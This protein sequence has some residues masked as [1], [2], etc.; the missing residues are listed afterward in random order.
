MARS[1]IAYDKDLP[2]VA[3]RL[4]W[5][6]PT[7]HLVKDDDAPTGWREDK[8]GRRPSKLLL[9]PKIRAEVDA[10]RENGYPGASEVTQR[11]FAYWFEEDHDVPGFPAPFRY[12]FCQREAIETL[13]WLVEV[14]RQRDAKALVETYGTVYQSDLVSKDIA[15]ETTKCGT[16]TLR[17]FGLNRKGSVVEIVQELPPVGLPRFAFKMAT[18]SGKTWVMAMAVVWSRFHK[19]M[20]PDSALSTNFLIVAPNVIVYQRLQKDFE[21]N[22]IFDQLPIIPPE[23]RGRFAQDVILRGEATEPGSAGSLFLTNVQQLYE[24]REKERT[25]DNALTAL[26]GQKPAKDLAAFSGPSMLDRLKALPDLV[27][28]NDEAHHVHRQGLAWSRSLLEIH[29]ALPK[30]IGAWLDFSATPWDQKRMHFPWTVVDYPLAQAVEDRIVKVPLIVTKETDKNQPLEDPDNVTKENVAEKYSYWLQAAVRR[31][32]A[33]WKVYKTKLG[34]RPVL[35]IM[36][37]KNV[38]A[39]ALGEYLWKTRAFG[40][41]PSEVL[42]IH[43]DGQG[44]VRKSDLE[45]AR[46]AARN[47]DDAKS[48]IKVI[49]SVMMLREGWDVRNVSVVLGLR[50]FT[51]EP[52]I[53]PQQMIGRGMRLMKDVSPD[54]TQTLE[55][56]G[57]R[58]LLRIL[59]EELENEEGVG[60]ASTDV[61]PP[62]AVVVEPV[63]ERSAYDIAIPVTKP[64]LERDVRKLADLDVRSLEAIYE[65]EELAEPY[66]IR[67]KMKFSTTGT[68]VHQENI[69]A[70]E[71][72][73]QE[74]LAE[75]TNK[76]MEDVG[77]P[78]RFAELYPAVKQYV[79]Q[80]CFGGAVDV[81]NG[82]ARSHLSRPDLREGIAKYLTRK[83]GELTV[84][85]RKTQF[86][87]ASFQLSDTKPF[88][89]RRNL[90]PLRAEKTIFNYVATYNG[91][92]RQ[93]AEFLDHAPD[94]LRFAA[95]GTTEQ[96]ASGT[97]FRVDYLKPSGAI[98]FYYPDWVAVQHDLD[99]EIINWVI[100][101]KGRV[102]EGTKEKD[103]AMQDWCH[104]VGTAT[105]AAWK[106][107]RVNQAEFKDDFE[108]FRA[109]VFKIVETEMFRKREARGA[110]LSHE[111]FLEW[112]DE[113]RREWPL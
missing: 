110:T 7:S 101:T 98:G 84:E 36:A 63:Q 35:F 13:V 62:A 50:P 67:L 61:N 11:L 54:R 106:Y 77:L 49:V 21:S 60:V 92:E 107:I 20:V 26:L 85:Q 71:P 27:V 12:Y 79:E 73:A 99:G 113:G 16:R 112:R 34:V 88:H 4:P 97:T 90:P 69:A 46:T 30:G 109:L 29:C 51:A 89:W 91:F 86:E 94:I 100:E 10:W 33:H 18:G 104:R 32:K 38:Y 83:I 78:G 37:E 1:V 19:L 24:S 8:S 80:R 64:G 68:E 81:E 41:K 14:A 2:E 47:I 44:D 75:I 3:G 43:T 5:T 111:E 55:V 87:N 48:R 105:G 42:V 52:E 59:R 56:L 53:L 95:L 66:R 23:W 58:N 17:R 108:S 102:W 45:K 93:F 103:A 15:F 40:L 65:Q 39:D 6:S 25:P 31:W 22:R 96:G 74:L 70:E 28:I 72:P 9:V 57:L 76:V 82:S